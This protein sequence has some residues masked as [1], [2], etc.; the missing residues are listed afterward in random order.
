[1][2]SGQAM[3]GPSFL[4]DEAW[5]VVLAPL[6][7]L[8]RSVTGGTVLLEGPVLTTELFLGPRLQTS[9]QDVPDVN[10]SVDL[11]SLWDKNQR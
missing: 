1:M 6:L 9:F 11:D 8:T 3:R 5:A 2:G 10:I 7:C 4:G